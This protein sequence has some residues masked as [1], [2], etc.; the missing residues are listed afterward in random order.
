MASFFVELWES[1]FTPG[2]TP[3]LI[4]ATHASFIMLIISLIVLIFFSR[5]IHFV[6][7][8]V[9]ACLLYGTVVW[10]IGELQR[11]KDEQKELD[12]KKKKEEGVEG[13]STEK[14]VE[15]QSINTGSVGTASGVSNVSGVKKKSKKL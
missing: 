10:F 14:K 8:L 11:V 4:K 13:V 15:E 6:N 9:I 3:A 7:L 12:E 5:S 2:T 1:I